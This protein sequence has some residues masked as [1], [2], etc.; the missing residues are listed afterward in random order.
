LFGC[1]Q[2]A[3]NET[4]SAVT[5]TTQTLQDDGRVQSLVPYWPIP[6]NPDEARALPGVS[7]LGLP[8]QLWSTLLSDAFSDVD[9]TGRPHPLTLTNPECARLPAAWKI[10]AARLS[11][12]EIDLPGNVTAWQSLALH[13]ETDLAQRIQLHVT[14]QP[15]CNS[16]RLERADFVHTLDHGFLLTFDLSGPY[17]A[18]KFIQW[19]ED[20]QRH[21]DARSALQSEPVQPFIIR[22]DKKIIPYSQA[23]LQWHDGS[24]GRYTVVKDWHDALQT[25]VLISKKNMPTAAWMTA[26]QE[27]L[28]RQEFSASTQSSQNLSH[29]ALLSNP[30]ALNGFFS[31][32]IS[33]KN[34]VRIRAHITEGLGTSQRFLRW[35]RRSENI[36]RSV[37]QTYAAQWDRQSDQMIISAVLQNPHAVTRVGTEQPV[38]GSMKLQLKDIDVE[39]TLLA[40]DF[41]AQQILSL[42]EKIADSERTSVQSTRCVSCH[43][44][45]DALRLARDGRTTAQRGLTPAQLSLMGVNRD[46]QHVINVRT[47][48][49]A[50]N[51][52][53]RFQEEKINARYPT[54]Q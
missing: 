30:S 54:Q 42:G 15:W 24:R 44:Y 47:L 5:A 2:R 28:S 50:D 27:L 18:K 26:R 10:S 39:Q 9:T 52:L 11:L 25:E 17:L 38:S 20:I 23:L 3:Y 8:S 29:P 4:G 31:K 43:G 40:N 35:D 1:K 48:R 46:E 36:T 32:Y 37:L 14:V 34:L 16:T 49:A 53:Q 41:S 6:K 22:S 12:Y 33:E 51:D 19:I 21:N 7:A 13:R 45:K